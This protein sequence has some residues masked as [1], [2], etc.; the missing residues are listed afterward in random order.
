MRCH[1]G[2][3]LALGVSGPPFR[4]SYD[5]KTVISLQD[6]YQ[7]LG[8]D[9]ESTEEVRSGRRAWVRLQWLT[10]GSCMFIFLSFFLSFCPSF[11]LSLSLSLSVSLSLSLSL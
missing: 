5:R 3:L 7:V 1:E 8:V 11:F 4:G 6:P 9:P 2:L 10:A